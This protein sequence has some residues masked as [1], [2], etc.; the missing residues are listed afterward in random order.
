MSYSITKG[1]NIMKKWIS[2]LVIF[3]LFTAVGVSFGGESRIPQHVQNIFAEQG[4]KANYFIWFPAVPQISASSWSNTLIVSN[5]NDAP[6]NV[7]C[8]YTS[9][10][11][12]QTIKQYKL[13][14]YEKKIYPLSNSGFGDDV[15]D[16][17][18]AC[19][20]MFG[21]EVLF[22]EGGKIATAWP[23]IF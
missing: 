21:A 23:P 7:S 8:W 10:S 22:L 12:T 16:I 15:Y 5:F 17:Y 1:D 19:D 18:C 14:F 11:Q 9:F 4:L 3:S 2:A 13:D 20:Q 6:I